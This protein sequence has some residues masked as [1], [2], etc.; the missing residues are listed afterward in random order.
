VLIIMLGTAEA[1]LRHSV[2]L[3]AGLVVLPAAAYALGRRHGLRALRARSRY[4]PERLAEELAWY[5]RSL[6]ELEE[7]AG[8]PLSAII[9]SYRRVQSHY[10]TPGDRP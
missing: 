3:V 5:R 9:A 2:V 1:L 4:L 10:Q 6:A 7:T 8:R